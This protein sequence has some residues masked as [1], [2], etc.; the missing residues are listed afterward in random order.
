MADLGFRVDG[1]LRT[2]LYRKCNFG[3]LAP[4]P[5]LFRCMPAV[6]LPWHSWRD[7]PSRSFQGEYKEGPTGRP[8]LYSPWSFLVQLADIVLNFV[9]K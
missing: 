3:R 2:L 5:R 6:C 8:F 9:N 7:I 1:G 4:W